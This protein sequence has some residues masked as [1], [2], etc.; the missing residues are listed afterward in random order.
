MAQSV[1]PAARI[2]YVDYDPLVLVHAR[3]GRR[4]PQALITT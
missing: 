1:A 3:P 2:V 4:R